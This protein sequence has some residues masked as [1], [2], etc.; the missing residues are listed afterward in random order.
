MLRYISFA[1]DLSAWFGKVFAWGVMI[2]TLGVSYEVVVRYFFRAPTSWAFD[3]SY[4]LY[5]TLF[6]VAGAHTRS[7]D[8]HGRGDF[9]YRLGK[10]R[11]DAWLELVVCL[12][13]FFPGV[14]GLIFSGWKYAERSW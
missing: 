7:R 4:M 12:I 2:M 11:T 13:C 10:P 3:L 9:I 5:G 6:M 14:T 1:D 8:G